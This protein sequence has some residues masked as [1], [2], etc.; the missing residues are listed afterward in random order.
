VE[1]YRNSK[2]KINGWD[3]ISKRKIYLRLFL[4]GG[5]GK[6]KNLNTLSFEILF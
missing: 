2:R 4:M 6:N 5:C 1:G 3:E